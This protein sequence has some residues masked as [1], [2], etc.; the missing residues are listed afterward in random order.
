MRSLFILGLVFGFAPFILLWPYIGLLA[1]SWISYMNPHKLT[2]GAAFGFPVADIIGISTLIGWA[3]SREKKDITLHPIVIAILVYYLWTT[4]TSVFA[5]HPTLAWDKWELFTKVLLI[6]FVAISLMRSQARL[7]AMIWVMVISCGYFA[8]KGG[9]FTFLTMGKYHV[10]GPPGTFHG[11]NNGIAVTFLMILPLLRYLQMQCQNRLAWMGLAAAQLLTVASVFGSQSRGAMVALA[12][13]LG[14]MLLRNRQF[15]VLILIAASGFGAFKLMPEAWQERQLSTLEWQDD[16]SAQGRIRMWQFAI[17]VANDNPAVGGGF[18]VFFHGP[19]RQQYMP[20]NDDG[21]IS[22]GRASHSIYFEVLGEHGYV[23]LAMYILI[24]VIAFFSAEHIMRRTRKRPDLRWARDLASMIQLSLIAFA[25][26]C[27]FLQKATF[28]LYFHILA[29][30]VITH[31]LV[32]RQLSE[33][34]PEVIPPSDPILS[35]LLPPRKPKKRPSFRPE[36]L[37]QPSF[38]EKRV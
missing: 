21:T 24:G 25:V 37:G 27:A 26:G 3:I 2:F 34:V 1:W 19:S 38:R 32:Q 14:Y 36:G 9:I 15:M 35:S 13:V 5:N 17:N 33:P 20:R 28:D 7:H 18:D 8:F 29:L 10:W 16:S 12:V 6:T 23:G 30:I 11:D 4:V 22:R 31:V